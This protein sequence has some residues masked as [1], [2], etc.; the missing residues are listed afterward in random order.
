MHGAVVAAAGHGLSD[1]M[2]KELAGLVGQRTN[3]LTL[4]NCQFT[5]ACMH[6]DDIVVLDRGLLQHDLLRGRDA[7]PPPDSPTQ[8][9]KMGRWDWAGMGDALASWARV[10]FQGCG[11]NQDG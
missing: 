3:F 5:V 9:P 6:E 11:A 10:R 7:P 1:D 8:M 2:N 4:A